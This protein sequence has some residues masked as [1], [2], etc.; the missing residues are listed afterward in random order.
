MPAQ[1]A[2]LEVLTEAVRPVEVTVAAQPVQLA[3]Q[4]AVSIRLTFAERALLRTRSAEAGT[5]VSAYVRQCVLEIEQL[6]EQVQ[7]A[8]AAMEQM[9][10][11]AATPAD[12]PGLP[13]TPKPGLLTRL[14][15]RALPVS[16]P[17]L[18]LRA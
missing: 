13:A 6:R 5:S 4:A 10:Q 3:R 14:M 16:A 12:A 11:R 15:R 1:P 17:T 7:Q 18:V 9:E 8:L 2:F